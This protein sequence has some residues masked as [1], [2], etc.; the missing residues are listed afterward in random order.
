MRSLALSALFAASL[1][2]AT[3]ASA[4]P[5][6][7]DCQAMTGRSATLIIP[8]TTFEASEIPVEIGSEF[9]LFTPDGLCA[10]HAI[11]EGGSLAVAVWED[12]P[13]T[14][15]E[16]GFVSGD[17]FRLAVWDPTSAT[18]LGTVPATLDSSFASSPVFASDAVYLVTALGSA[19]EDDPGVVQDFAFGLEPS[20]P[21]PFV[22]AT[23]I[24]YTIAET[25][26]VR[27]EVYNLLGQRVV[28]LVDEPREPG[29]YEVTFRP[30]PHLAS[31]TYIYRLTTDSFSEFHRMTLLR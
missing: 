27:L 22:D 6:F 3:A 18:E 24:G 26:Q 12:D 25:T 21:N 17:T 20:Y 31:G 11:W 4:L 7:A 14:S 5:H 30:P 23:H 13:Q 2:F 19:G 10:G 9:A 29:D 1:S 28:A 15:A 16:D 8:L